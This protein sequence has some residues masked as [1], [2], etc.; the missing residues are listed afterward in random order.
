MLEDRLN[1][2]IDEVTGISS[3]DFS[4]MFG[5]GSGEFARAYLLHKNKSEAYYFLHEGMSIFQ[6]EI[7]LL[8]GY[9][10][11]A[12]GSR[13]YVRHF[14]DMIFSEEKLS[15]STVQ[16]SFTSEKGPKLLIPFTFSSS[17][18]P[19]ALVSKK[20]VY[21]DI[22]YRDGVNLFRDFIS[23]VGTNK[24]AGARDFFKTEYAHVRT[25]EQGLSSQLKESFSNHANPSTKNKLTGLARSVSY[26]DRNMYKYLLP[27]FLFLRISSTP[28]VMRE[29]FC[30]S[31]SFEEDQ[32]L[33]QDPNY[34]ALRSG[35]EYLK[36]CTNV[37]S[38]AGMSALTYYI[39]TQPSDNLLQIIMT[40]GTGVSA[41]TSVCNLISS[42]GKN[43]DGLLASAQS[44]EAHRELG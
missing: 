6:P 2:D 41:L 23:A 5:K 9:F 17:V 16:Y 43:S 11:K 10:V 40:A 18:I 24:L 33:L 32:R 12:K 35:I 7:E 44:G 26:H 30:R 31:N 13:I 39:D 27:T 42:K 8:E 4:R 28:H 38:L 3:N 19:T 14:Y 22:V 20:K 21:S 34:P 1:F 15:D 37:I 36:H 29:L 25:L